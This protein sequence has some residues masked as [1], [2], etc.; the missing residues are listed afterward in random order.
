MKSKS[1]NL[2]TSLG[3][4]AAMLCVLASACEQPFS[5]KGSFK[6]ELVVYA[7]LSNVADVQYVR[8]YRTYDPPGFDPFGHLTDNQVTGAQVTMSE[9]QTVIAFRDTQIVRND[10]IRY[11][12]PIDAYVAAPFR[13]LKGKSY[14]LEVQTLDGISTTAKIRLPD[15][16]SI[17][18]SNMSA[19]VAPSASTLTTI[20]FAMYISPFAKGFILKFNL[21]FES[22][23]GGIWVARQREVPLAIVLTAEGKEERYFPTLT[24]SPGG[25][26]TYTL[27][28]QQFKIHAYQTIIGEIYRDHGG[29]VRFTSAGFVLTQVEPALYN[30]YGIANGFRDPNTIRVDEPDFTNIAGGVGVFGGFVQDTLVVALP[31]IL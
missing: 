27:V 14:A 6:E 8:V 20:A 1:S 11:L 30:Y 2:V 26:T 21:R 25:E 18:V 7:I 4:R 28:S 12:A 10:T 19:L 22:L 29:S 24:R 5:P 17:V 9:D 23:E 31:A 3:I 13:A 16:G 15:A